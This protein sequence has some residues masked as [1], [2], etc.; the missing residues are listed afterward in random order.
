MSALAYPQLITVEDYLTGEPLSEVKHEFVAGEV[1]AMAG[2]S[3]V[4]GRLALRLGSLLEQHLRG[5][6]CE[7]FVG[8]MKV[9][10]RFGLQD[11]FYYPDIVVGC[12]PQDTDDYFL[13]F[14]KLIIEVLSPA[15]ERVDK[16]E[17]LQHYTSIASLEEYVLVAQ[18]RVQVIIY[19]RRANWAG[20]MI[21]E[22]EDK[23]TLESV[24]LTLTLEQLYEHIQLG[25][26]DEY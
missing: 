21:T 22:P 15:T 2:A 24:D 23:L 20:E 7:A 1:Y 26:E 4:H 6:P 3:R 16:R 11:V 19:R 5:L 18:D 8:D 13:R 14:P 9:R 12:D 17:K 10:I 25:R